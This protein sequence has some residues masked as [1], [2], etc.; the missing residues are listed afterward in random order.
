MRAKHIGW[1]DQ[2]PHEAHIHLPMLTAIQTVVQRWQVLKVEDYAKI[3]VPVEAVVNSLSTPHAYE[4]RWDM[5]ARL[6]RE[7]HDPVGGYEHCFTI[8]ASDDELTVT[9]TLPDPTWPFDSLASATGGRIR[10]GQ[11]YWDAEPT[12]SQARPW[13]H[14]FK[15]PISDGTAV[16]ADVGSI[17]WELDAVYKKSE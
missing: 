17:A 10:G 14:R 5:D 12:P 1:Q 2:N 6:I 15:R 11:T 3:R 13:I 4:E 9:T 16:G 8:A 7:G